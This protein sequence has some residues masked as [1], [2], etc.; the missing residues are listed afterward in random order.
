VQACAPC[1]A[2][3]HNINSIVVATAIVGGASA[4]A[5]LAVAATIVAHERDRVSMR[6]RIVVGLMMANAVYSTANT[7]PLNE[8]RTGVVN[9][10][11]MALS[12]EAIRFGRAWCLL[13]TH[14][15]FVYWRSKRPPLVQLFNV[16]TS[17]T[18]QSACCCEVIR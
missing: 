3:V 15:L 2:S 16:C 9:C 6:D 14:L 10:G 4:V 17:R 12:F 1:P 13:L 18:V 11:R 5:C 7:I 8:L